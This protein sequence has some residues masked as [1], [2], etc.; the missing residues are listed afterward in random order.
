MNTEL[1][2]FSITED[3]SHVEIAS[4][5]FDQWILTVAIRLYSKSDQNVLGM[6]HV[7]F[8]EAEGFRVLNENSMLQFPWPKSTESQSFLY[9]V[10]KNGWLEMEQKAGNMIDLPDGA[11]EYVVIGSNE[12]V[13]VIAYADPKRVDS[14]SF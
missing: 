9:R 10:N 4:V 11:K 7:I 3:V 2:K 13:S 6:A 14:N 1:S 12:C 5:N 8:E